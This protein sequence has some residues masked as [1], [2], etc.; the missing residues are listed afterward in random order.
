MVKTKIITTCLVLLLSA[1]TLN[2][3]SQSFEKISIEGTKSSF[4][5][6]SGYNDGPYGQGHMYRGNK[7]EATFKVFVYPRTKQAEDR[8][9]GLSDERK[10][11][12]VC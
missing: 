8:A 1:V 10:S 2:A 3:C 7:G 9:K 12:R 11:I 4:C 5:M 6:P